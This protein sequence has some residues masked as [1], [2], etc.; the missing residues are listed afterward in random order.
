LNYCQNFL[1]LIEDLQLPGRPVVFPFHMNRVY[2]VSSLDENSLEFLES[3][4][5]ALQGEDGLVC[6]VPVTFQ[7]NAGVYVWK[8]FNH[9]SS[10]VLLSNADDSLSARSPDTAEEMEMLFL[11][12]TDTCRNLLH[13]ICW[14]CKKSGANDSL[15]RCKKCQIA[16][17][18]SKE[19]QGTDWKRHKKHCSRLEKWNCKEKKD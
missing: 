18:S 1:E 13:Q 3:L 11:R 10:E 6:S 9:Q 2:V 4:G 5:Q 15:Q 16:H 19:C 12:E 8:A 17:Y 7:N 14:T